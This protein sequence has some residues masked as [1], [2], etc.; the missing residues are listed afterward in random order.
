M[1]RIMKKA[2][3][4]SIISVLVLFAIP[5]SNSLDTDISN[6]T[7][8]F[9]A[10]AA[11]TEFSDEMIDT[12]AEY[13]F[14]FGTEINLS[15]YDYTL[16][17][18]QELMQAIKDAYPVEFGTFSFLS[19]YED[20]KYTISYYTSSLKAAKI[21]FEYSNSLTSA[22][23]K[24]MVQ[25]QYDVIEEIASYTTGMSDF[26]TIVFVHDYLI[27]NCEYNYDFVNMTSYTNKIIREQ[28]NAYAALVNGKGVCTS[29]TLAYQYILNYLGIE[30]EYVVS[31]SMGHTWNVVK[32]DGKWY[33]VDLT[34]D[35]PTYSVAS[36]D[37]TGNANRTYLL[38]TSSEML[39]LGHSGWDGDYT[40][41][42]TAYSYMPRNNNASQV[43]ENDL[44]YFYSGTKF[45]SSNQYGSNLS[46][47][48]ND[49]GQGLE[50]NGDR[51]FYGDGLNIVSRQ[52][53]NPSET[54]IVYTMSNLASTN[55]VYSLFIVENKISYYYY[56]NTFSTAK[57]YAIQGSTNINLCTTT[58]T[59][60]NFYCI[61]CG[62]S[63]LVIDTVEM[64]TYTRTYDAIR[65]NWEE[66]D[67][68]AGYRVYMQ[69]DGTYTK[70]ET[71]SGGDI[72][73][74]RVEGLDAN[75]EYS[76]KVKAYGKDGSTTVW[77]EASEAYYAS[78]K[79]EQA[80]I[81][82]S[83]STCDEITITWNA[84]SGADGYRVYMLINGTYTSLETIS[85]SQTSYTISGLDYDSQYSFKV[86]TYVRNDDGVAYFLDASEA[87]YA[88]TKD[89]QVQ[90]TTYTR[91]YDAIRVNWEEVS[92]ADGYR[93]FV[94][95]DN[96]WVKLATLYGS[97]TTTYRA[98]GFEN[99]T[100]Y[101]FQVIAFIRDETGTAIWQEE[102][103]PYYANTISTQVQLTTYTRTY[104]AIRVNWE[105]ITVADGYR[106]FVL[107]DNEWV[108]LAT[109]YGSDTLTYRASGFDANTEY[110]FMVKAFI[111][112]DS[113]TAIFQEESEPYY[114]STKTDQV[115]IKSYS[116]TSDAIRVNWDLIS[117]ADGY[118]VYVLLDGSWV[119]MGTISSTTTTLRMSGFK[120]NTTYTFKV[121]AYVRNDDGTAIW[122]DDG[123][124]YQ[125]STK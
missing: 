8:S 36:S 82:S 12:I 92:V 90:M 17:Q 118:R 112:D 74:Y 16:T 13:I 121:N 117:G 41:T 109:L 18:A 11:S 65:I 89:T 50:V 35:D 119:N 44:W 64:T 4:S 19:G 115:S 21:T 40:C 46:L 122:L 68:A 28:Y 99:S 101:C 24:K 10:S 75:S 25:E 48:S 30:C 69:I 14:D 2:L 3:L 62:K 95:V 54:T 85:S 88:N 63:N 81:T 113:G 26:E 53:S 37:I 31:S 123:E 76:F 39:R 70:I 107:V 49:I 15:S 57:Y 86:N 104:D 71:I 51:Y 73:T 52:L 98:S 27:L 66:V 125:A 108:K 83:S 7:G 87:F 78:T 77:G 34:Y 103:E 105:E 124:L 84:I 120:A 96:E 43:Y 102:S 100:E 45:Y 20:F 23:F 29:Y 9:E 47:I 97:D 106:V 72:T 59:Y 79:T 110:C 80:V 56:N 91:T 1:K 5:I 93:V 67:D 94:L 114:A 58:H 6:F 116:S 38:R 32:L 111:R 42:S 60:S 22:E 33:H 61:Y 55:R